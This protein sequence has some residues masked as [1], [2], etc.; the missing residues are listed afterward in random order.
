MPQIFAPVFVACHAQHAG[1]RD[2]EDSSSCFRVPMV[3]HL[4]YFRSAIEREA[5]RM[6][7]KSV[8]L[9]TRHAHAACRCTHIPLPCRPSNTETHLFRHKLPGPLS[10]RVLPRS[11]MLFRGQAQSSLARVPDI[12]G[13]KLGPKVNAP[14]F[15]K[16]K[17]PMV[18]M[19]PS[20]LWQVHAELHS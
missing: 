7:W 1:E 15:Q 10:R 8:Q 16:A 14:K 2:K 12:W 4:L 6:W 3:G 5:T 9:H 13:W 19:V 17:E 18:T 11:E 20:Q